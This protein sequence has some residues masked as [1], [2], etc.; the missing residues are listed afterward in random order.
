MLN[1][2]CDNGHPVILSSYHNNKAID[3]LPLCT[4]THVLPTQRG[5]S[6]TSINYGNNKED[7]KP[8]WPHLLVLRIHASAI[9]SR[10][11]QRPTLLTPQKKRRCCD[12][13]QHKSLLSRGRQEAIVLF[14]HGNVPRL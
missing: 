5:V 10:N 8:P 4:S 9:L 12:K 11:H 1:A 2:E 6:S 13:R 14:D 7:N 3:A